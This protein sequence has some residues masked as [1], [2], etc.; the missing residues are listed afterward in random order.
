[1]T[2]TV[3]AIVVIASEG[4]AASILRALA[5]FMDCKVR[6]QTFYEMFLSFTIRHGI[7]SRET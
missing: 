5:L 7:T 2:V 4:L 1:M 3:L 6:L